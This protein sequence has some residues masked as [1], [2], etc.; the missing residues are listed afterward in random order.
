MT[1]Q[2]TAPLAT[3]EASAS[4]IRGWL[5]EQK[6]EWPASVARCVADW[7]VETG[8]DHLDDPA[9]WVWVILEDSVWGCLEDDAKSDQRDEICQRVLTHV[10]AS[11]EERWVYVFFRTKMEQE[12]LDSGEDEDEEDSE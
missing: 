11:G 2:P 1:S 7:R 3:S 4:E 12:E 5:Q 9:V 10:A 6:E 8:E